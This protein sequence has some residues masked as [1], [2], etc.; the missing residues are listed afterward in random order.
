L[1]FHEDPLVASVSPRALLSGVPLIDS[2][3]KIAGTLSVFDVRAKA[4]TR[5]QRG[6]LWKLADVV[7]RLSRRHRGAAR[8][9]GNAFVAGDARH[10]H[11]PGETGASSEGHA[12]AP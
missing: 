6:A 1:R 8:R 7:T 11:G 10:A 12:C 5:I 3:G 9:R 4:L 2:G